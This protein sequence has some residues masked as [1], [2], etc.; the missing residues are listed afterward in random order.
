MSEDNYSNLGDNTNN[1]N[2]VGSSGQ[3]KK[4]KK[5]MNMMM[6]SNTNI[7]SNNLNNM[8]NNI[9]DK[10]VKE[11]YIEKVREKVGEWRAMHETGFRDKDGN[12]QKINLDQ[13]AN[14]IGISRKTL[15][16]Y[17]LQLRRAEQLGFDFERNKSEKM[18]TLRKFVKEETKR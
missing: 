10:R 16:D 3:Q 2:N 6:G 14:I 12:L 15:D 11:R 4:K 9:N 7:S 1:N 17:Y 18:G 5:L 8:R 13:A